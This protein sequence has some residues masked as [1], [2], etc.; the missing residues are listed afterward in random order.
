MKPN[1]GQESATAF[2]KWSDAPSDV[3]TLSI[4]PPPPPFLLA[5]SPTAGTNTFLF[6]HCD[7]QWTYRMEALRTSSQAKIRSKSVKCVETSLVPTCSNRF[8]RIRKY[9]SLLF[10]YWRRL[11]DLF[12]YL[13][14]WLHQFYHPSFNLV[15]CDLIGLHKFD[16]VTTFSSSSFKWDPSSSTW[17]VFTVSLVCTGT[18]L[19]LTWL[20]CCGR[21]LL[22]S[23]QLYVPTFLHYND[24]KKRGS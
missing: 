24:H 14:D 23:T 6:N 10:F 17:L 18:L 15:L 19:S 16:I 21:V 3:N 4:P 12:R 22:W 1:L 11:L 20:S 7:L 13:C 5:P 2:A 9:L 8:L